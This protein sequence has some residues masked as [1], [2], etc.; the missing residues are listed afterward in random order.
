MGKRSSAGHHR[1]GG[2]RKVHIPDFY[3]GS[4][5]S[6]W[7]YSGVAF[8]V[9]CFGRCWSLWGKQ[10]RCFLAIRVLFSSIPLL[11]LRDSPLLLMDCCGAFNLL[12]RFFFQ[13]PSSGK[14]SLQKLVSWEFSAYYSYP[15]GKGPS[16]QKTRNSRHISPTFL[17]KYFKCVTK[18]PERG[19]I[20][21]SKFCIVN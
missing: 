5:L 19:W 8:G 6:I 20:L 10:R 12:S 11:P 4:S 16:G 14:G 7:L 15:M 1:L 3:P 13:F 2:D 9:R 21:S 18:L 17:M